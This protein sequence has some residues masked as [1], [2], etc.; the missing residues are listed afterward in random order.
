VFCRLHAGAVVPKLHT[1]LRALICAVPLAVAGGATL[2]LTLS[3]A[4]AEAPEFRI[5]FLNVMTEPMAP[6]SGLP[7]RNGAQM[8]IDEIN[9]AGGVMVDGISHRLV[10]IERD[11]DIR[12]DAAATGARALINVDSV[13]AIVGPQISTLAIAAA[14][15]AEFAQV[16]LISPMASN[17]AVTAGRAMVFR[18]AFLDEYQGSALARFAFDSLG[19][20]RASAL[21]DEANP[22]SRDIWS[23]F[24]TTF[25]ARGGRVVAEETFHT[26][27]ASDYRTQLRRLIAERPDAI[28]LPNYAVYDSVQV[29][30]ARDLGFRGRFLGSDSWDPVAM[31]AIPAADG[32]VVVANWDHRSGGDTTRAF[33]SRYTARFGHDPRTTAAATFDA[34]HIL[35]NAATR[36]RTL[37]GPALATAIGAT[38]GH[39]GVVTTYRFR[40]S[41]D[42]VRGG[43]ILELRK[44]TTVIRLLD[45]P[46]P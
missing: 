19:V 11:I 23:L 12:A 14:A 3:C 13:H 38:D 22:Y 21:Y 42:P 6:V 34:M 17:P 16:P 5:G 18:L 8:A 45:N 24:R 44:G 26:D 31:I 1:M 36:A 20:R 27:V 2:A 41:G 28:L 46:E 37:N 25:E 39:L 29:R 40:G 4:P 33:V 32:S 30:Q 10:L 15:V 43:T 9:A 7:G 35:A